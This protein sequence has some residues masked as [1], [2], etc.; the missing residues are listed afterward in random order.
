MGEGGIIALI[1]LKLRK[2]D[3]FPSNS[4]TVHSH[5]EYWTGEILSNQLDYMLQS[6]YH[7]EGAEEIR[8]YQTMMNA[9]NIG[10]GTTSN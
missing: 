8:G 9:W 3:L 2:P 4:G 6:G 7:I 1:K 10:G 5:V